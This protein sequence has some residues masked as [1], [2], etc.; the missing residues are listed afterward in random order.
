MPKRRDI[1]RQQDVVRKFLAVYCRKR[2]GR[3]DGGLCDDCRELLDYAAQRLR[4]CPLDPKPKCKDCPI[5]C[6][7]D[8]HRARMKDV[9]RTGGMHY[10]AR[11]RLDWLV[12]YFLS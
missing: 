4:R 9:M 8:E 3:A 7:D 6:Y 11:G 12:R 1:G 10:V 5:H 2:H